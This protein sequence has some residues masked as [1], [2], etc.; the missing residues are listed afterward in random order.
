MKRM[1][2][3]DRTSERATER[4]RERAGERTRERRTRLWRATKLIAPWLLAAV[5]LVLIVQQARHVDWPA[6]W[7]ALKQQPAGRL[8]AAA[9]LALASFT[10]FAGYD[11]I[12]RRETH[13]GLSPPRTLRIAA[14]CYAFN[15]N[16]GSLLGGVAMKLR[17][18]ERAGVGA[19]TVARVIALS[20]ATNWLGYLVVAGA[21]LM[22]APP[23]LPERFLLPDTSG[24]L[25]ALGAAL[26]AG[27]P[28]YLL[29]AWRHGGKVMSLRGHRFALPRL[30]VAWAQP[31]LAAANWMLMGVIVWLL[32]ARA[33]RR[34][35][36][37]WRCCCSLRWPVWPRMFPRGWA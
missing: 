16:F 23:A 33:R 17:L 19:A 13:H 14:I 3:G 10:L 9:A 29:L 7:L 18:Y 27:G 37:C 22:L 30:P 1:H 35:P 4:T 32:L 12:G 5:V 26:F 15:I 8:L 6:V 31:A 24:A 28:A 21:V 36:R 34:T 11:L 20:L 25:R 2:S